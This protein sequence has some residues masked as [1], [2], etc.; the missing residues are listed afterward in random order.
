[1]HKCSLFWR[2]WASFTSLATESPGPST[3]YLVCESCHHEEFLPPYRTAFHSASE[4]FPAIKTIK[5]NFSGEMFPVYT[6]G[7]PQ[8]EWACSED[9][10]EWR[11]TIWKLTASLLHEQPSDSALVAQ[12]LTVPRA[13]S[14]WERDKGLPWVLLWPSRTV[15]AAPFAPPAPSPGQ[16]YLWQQTHWCTC[17]RSRHSTGVTRP[18]RS[19]Q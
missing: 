9:G 2:L 19:K 17:P 6:W 16:G 15:W 1:M 3:E 10:R 11:Q 4:W 8:L 12:W 5:G 13:S 14:G 18:V 7:G